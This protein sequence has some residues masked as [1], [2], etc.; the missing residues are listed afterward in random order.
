MSAVAVQEIEEPMVAERADVR[1]FM[2]RRSE[3]R[4]VKTPVYPVLGPSGATVGHKAGE[5]LEFRD[6]VLRLPLQGD[7]KLADGRSVPVDGVV[8]WLE[9][10]RLLGNKEEG[11]WGVDPTAPAPS[12]AEIGK[13]AELSMSL[14]AAGLLRFIEQES[15][16][17]ARPTLLKAAQTALEAAEGAQG[18]IQADLDK[19]VAAAAHAARQEGI[20]AGLAQAAREKAKG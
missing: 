19:R 7:V 9:N 4:L 8:E 11:F 20:T 12:E 15:A 1:L 13:L 10:H 5:A 18:E 16:G 3:L 6:G 17:W 2:S 14:D